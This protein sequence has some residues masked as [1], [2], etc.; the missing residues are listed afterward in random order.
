LHDPLIGNQLY[1]SANNQAPEL[2]EGAS[3]VAADFS[4]HAGECGELLGVQ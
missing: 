3:G 4:G 2:G 1:V